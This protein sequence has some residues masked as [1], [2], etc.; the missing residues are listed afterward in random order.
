[1]CVRVSMS[2][3]SCVC[4]LIDTEACKSFERTSLYFNFLSDFLKG[5]SSSLE[6]YKDEGTGKKWQKP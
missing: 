4:I 1:M 5:L 2:A 6:I 3:S